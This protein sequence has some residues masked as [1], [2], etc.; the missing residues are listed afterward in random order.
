MRKDRFGDANRSAAGQKWTVKG[1]SWNNYN[2][3]YWTPCAPRGAAGTPSTNEES[4]LPNVPLP[5]R[6][7]RG[8]QP[9][10][11]LAPRGRRVQRLR[12]G[13]AQGVRSANHGPQDLRAYGWL[14]AYRRGQ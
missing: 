11:R 4:H 5:R 3:L 2:G 1:N 7:L 6:L 14:L 8:T 12:R 13:N 10:N 9:R